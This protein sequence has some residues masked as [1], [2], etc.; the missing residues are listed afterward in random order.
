[1]DL[2]QIQASH[3]KLSAPC[4]GAD[5][6]GTL[7]ERALKSFESS[8]FPSTRQER[9]K[10]T[11]TK[12][13]QQLSFAVEAG[14]GLGASDIAAHTLEAAAVELV[15]VNGSYRSDLSRAQEGLEV[16]VL[17]F[18]RALE[19]H[20]GIMESILGSLAT[21]EG[22]PDRSFTALNTAFVGDGALVHV[23]RGQHLEG[24]IHLLYVQDSAGSPCTSHP[25]NLI[26]LEE[27]C[28]AAVLESFVS[29]GDKESFTNAVTEVKLGA[30]ARLEHLVWGDESQSS[31]H[32]GRT[33]ISLARDASYSATSLWFGGRWT[34]NDVDVRFEGPG[35][36]C[37]LNG[38]YIGGGN[39]HI[40]NHTSIEHMV[41]NCQ[42]RQLYKG[43]LGGSAKAV[44]NGRVHI[45]PDAQRTDSAMSN[46]NLLLTERASVNTKPE[47]EIYADDV[48]AS[49][50]TTVGQLEDQAIFYLRT[51]G[52]PQK[53]AE[54]ILTTAFAVD[55]LSELRTESM[56]DVCLKR[57]EA[58]LDAVLEG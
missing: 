40:D 43:V 18:G 27:N 29:V 4:A 22:E 11:S 36:E 6:L 17:A 38:L 13:L 52:I 2:N 35:S 50:G 47:L 33:E 20:G 28:E 15:F 32:V 53:Q 9:W 16:E 57:I 5:W 25:R 58:Q 24:V 1:M 56:R 21:F 39:Q 7:R 19:S 48:K 54:R 10:Y 55:V 45:H 14:R 46:R 49:H 30:G 51:R 31:F 44:F 42:S 3:S 26:V 8:G 23:R 37:V 12:A 41:P 34:R